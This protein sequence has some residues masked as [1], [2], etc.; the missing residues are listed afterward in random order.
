VLYPAHTSVCLL[1]GNG[2]ELTKIT[3]TP[4]PGTLRTQYYYFG[5][6]GI[7]IIWMREVLNDALSSQALG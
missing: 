7:N 1:S 6:S 3:Y 2:V 4:F 5:R